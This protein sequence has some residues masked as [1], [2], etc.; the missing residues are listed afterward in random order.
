MRTSAILLGL[1]ATTVAASS[2]TATDLVGS[3]ESIANYTKTLPNGDNITVENLTLH[4]PYEL[5]DGQ[6]IF[7]DGSETLVP[8]VGGDFA[9]L[10]QTAV[11]NVDENGKP[12][13]LDEVYVHHLV[14]FGSGFGMV[15]AETLNQVKDFP[16]GTGFIVLNSSD[17]GMN[18][19]LLSNKNL[20]PIE[21][22]LH[23]AAKQC[24]E[25]Y[26]APGKGDLCTPATN[27]TFACCGDGALMGENGMPIACGLDA[28]ECNCAT[29]TNGS[30]TTQYEIQIDF[31]LTRDIEKIQPINSWTLM[32]PSCYEGIGKGLGVNT[33]YIEEV[34]V[35]G[36][37]PFV[38]GS[39]YH[40]VFRNNTEPEK[41]STGRWLAHFDGVVRKA[42]GHLHTGGLN[43][44]LK[45]NGED[46]CTA[47]TEYGTEPWSEDVD[48]ARD[49][50]GHL[51]NIYDCF[52]DTTIPEGVVI[53]AGDLVEVTSYYYVGDDDDRLPEGGGG[54]HLNVMS[55]MDLW[56]EDTG[57]EVN[58]YYQL[59]RQ[60]KGDAS[61]QLDGSQG[62]HNQ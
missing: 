45:I 61:V 7:T 43:I 47:H 34:V 24:N 40:N 31:M 5:R 41:A 4:F 12:V 62:I 16:E 39:V 25:C 35:G 9:M 33:S 53:Q 44:S 19:H 6:I 48:N 14:V 3:I 13:S 30:T 49:E 29:T 2:A 18:A 32:A 51:I 15:G 58:E 8:G 10:G 28:T 20:Q 52:N 26:F 55:Y 36:C 42:V 46:I 57:G 1:V 37:T 60:E 17:F 50:Y 54:S 56:F 23:I 22:S 21:D 59:P 38:E 11:R 27:G